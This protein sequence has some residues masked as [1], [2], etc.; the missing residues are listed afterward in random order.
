MKTIVV[1]DDEFGLAEVLGATLSD[2]GH[3]V[4]IA[5]N[6]AQGL[7]VMAEHPPDL[8]LLDYMMPL[9]DG[10]GVLEAMRSDPRLAGVPVLMMSAM[11]ESTVRARCSGYRAFLRK[12]FAFDALVDAVHRA[13]GDGA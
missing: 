6:G 4:H 13:L 9:L 1:V 5:A 8:V 7:S 12:P 2:L 11:P 3:R 10:P